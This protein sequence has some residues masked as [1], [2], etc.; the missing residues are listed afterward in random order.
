MGPV[1]AKSFQEH[2]AVWR[3][4]GEAFEVGTACSISGGPG[5]RVESSG[6]LGKRVHERSMVFSERQQ[7]GERGACQGCVEPYYLRP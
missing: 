2:S 1:C 7:R 3:R 5:V 6:C 4:A